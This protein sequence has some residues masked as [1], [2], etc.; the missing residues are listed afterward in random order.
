M[1]ST[2]SIARDSPH[3]Q[4]PVAGVPGSRRRFVISHP[5]PEKSAGW[6]TPSPGLALF[7]ESLRAVPTG[8][9]NFSGTLTPGC[10]RCGG[11]HPGLFSFLPNG[12]RDLQVLS[13]CREVGLAG[14]ERLLFEVDLKLRASMLLVL[15]VTSVSTPGLKKGAVGL[16]GVTLYASFDFGP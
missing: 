12:R 5:S 2:V 11:L 4:R 6:G 3:Q 15:A 9:L 13:D 10:V 1:D 7:S 16:E 8:L 14:V